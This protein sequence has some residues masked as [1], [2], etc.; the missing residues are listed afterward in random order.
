MNDAA[1]DNTNKLS[2]AEYKQACTGLEM[3]LTSYSSANKSEKE[4]EWRRVERKAIIL[5]GAETRAGNAAR[6][7]GAMLI[8][9]YLVSSGNRIAAEMFG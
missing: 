5:R 6:E 8:S 4:R 3:A 1:N 7:W 2:A 9:R